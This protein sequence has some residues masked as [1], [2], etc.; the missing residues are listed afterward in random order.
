MS[1]NQ[2]AAAKRD[3]FPR[4]E[5]L[6]PM[7]LDMR[8]KVR[9]YFNQGEPDT[10]YDYISGRLNI[11]GEDDR[12]SQK[13]ICKIKAFVLRLDRLNQTG[14]DLLSTLDSV[15][16]NVVRYYE[17][18][19]DGEEIKA[20]ISDEIEPGYGL[21]LLVIDN[22]KTHPD[23]RGRNIGLLATLKVIE[24]F[25]GSCEYV[26]VRPF[27]LQFTAHNKDPKNKI[28]KAKA[29]AAFESNEKKAFQ[30]LRKHWEQLGF[31]RVEGSDVFI[32]STAYRIP[33]D[34][35]LFKP[36]RPKT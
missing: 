33:T 36:S 25:S 4:I 2:T 30:K 12:E 16:D 24:V 14:G 31:K 35:A 13:C 29:Y 23:Y 15:D 7:D 8:F 19:Y 10:F 20:S 34:R 27:P 21:N 32:L 11:Y 3:S 22:V 6:E 5:D 1:N 26:A 17:A 9:A 18:L 28:L